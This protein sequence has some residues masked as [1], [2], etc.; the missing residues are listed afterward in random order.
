MGYKQIIISPLYQG[1]FIVL[2][3]I[4]G[5]FI[6]RILGKPVAG[7][8]TAAL[9]LLLFCTLNAIAGIFVPAIGFYLLK[10]IGMFLL[11]FMLAFLFSSM[12]SGMGYQ[13]Y[14]DNAMIFVAP[15]MYYPIMLAIMGV[16]RIIRHL[17]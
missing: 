10:S 9:L 2:L 15:V 12:I 3:T 5:L 1:A 6:Y 11:L 4:I 17:I 7:W 13:E 16:A 8:N 14:G